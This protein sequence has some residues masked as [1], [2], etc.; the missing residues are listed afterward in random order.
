[1]FRVLIA[2]DEF[3]VRIGVKNSIPWE[4]YDMSVIA[5]VSNGKE[6]WDI[7][8]RDRPDLIITDIRM[9]IMDGMELIERIREK[10][11]ATKIVILS[12]LSEF[13][14][15]RKALSLGVNDYIL[16]LT[17]T[18]EEMQHVIAKISSEMT[19]KSAPVSTEESRVQR[20]ERHEKLLKDF[21]FRELYSVEEFVALADG[22]QWRS[23]TD[24]LLLCLMEIDRYDAL[25]DSYK[26]EYGHLTEMNLFNV[27]HNVVGTYEYA[28]V[29][30]DQ[31]NRFM[32]LISSAHVQ[33]NES[34]QQEMDQLLQ[35]LLQHLRQVLFTYFNTTVTFGMSS[36][37][38]G[39]SQ[40]KALYKESLMTLEMKFVRG[41]G[42]TLWYSQE[43]VQQFRDDVRGAFAKLESSWSHLEEA[44]RKA[45]SEQVHLFMDAG[46]YDPTD[47]LNFFLRLMQVPLFT[48]RLQGESVW[49]NHEQASA[50]IRDART[51]REAMG[52]F[53]NYLN[54]L[55]QGSVKTPKWSKEVAEAV[56]YIEMHYRQAITLQELAKQVNLSAN[57]FST[58]FKKETKCS[59][60][61]YLIQY[62]IG[63]AKELLLETDHRTYEIAEMV[64]IPDH[65]YFSRIFKKMTGMNPKSFRI[66]PD[67]NGEYAYA[68]QP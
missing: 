65:S 19:V 23:S 3:L 2:E 52:Y 29:V 60:I 43:N 39:Y 22:L 57:Y 44:L 36:I 62:R 11:H 8:V 32:L 13:E 34:F 48:V 42:S 35:H 51:L 12:C 7:Y 64:G 45:L 16:K 41:E 28:Q 46:K 9:P 4:Q 38:S 56:A 61:D 1:M 15:A 58:L 18:P 5:D 49:S 40:I 21:L 53:R 50:S 54:Q 37:H 10:D 59:P 6:A 14:L 27:L 25:R 63:K 68:D 17:M 30:H 67:R 66:S 47:V 26:D 31:K 20:S 55:I 33:G 24:H